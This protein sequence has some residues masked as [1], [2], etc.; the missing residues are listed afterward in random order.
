MKIL[1]TTFLLIF[2]SFFSFAQ[3]QEIDSLKNVISDFENSKNF[4]TNLNYLDAL[5]LL[6]YKYYAF[7]PD[8]M[9]ILAKKSRKLCEQANY[10]IGKIEAIR[11][12]GIYFDV[13]GDFPQALKYFQE[14]MPLAQKIDY[15][16]GIGRLYNNIALIYEMEGKYD[17]VLENHFKSLKIKEE[18]GDKEGIAASLNNIASIYNSQANY[19][20]ALTHYFKSLGICQEIGD[21]KGIATALNNIAIIYKIQGN[22]PEALEYYFKSLKIDEQ[23]ENK[24][25]IAATL[26]GI[27]IV[28]YDQDKYTE[29]LENQ[30]K[31]LKINEEIGNKQGIAAN[32][33]DIAN[34]YKEQ[35]EYKIALENLFK[36][37]KIK[38]EMGNKQGINISLNHI[39]DI[40]ELQEKHDLAL[41]YYSQSLTISLNLGDQSLISSNKNG[42]ARVYFSLKNYAKALSYAQEGL[43]L[44]RKIGEK[45][46]I[47]NISHTLS[48]IYAATD[49]YKEAFFYYQEFKT[50]SDSLYN[51]NTDEKI[52][53]LQAE[54]KYD[55]KLAA[56]QI[57]QTKKDLETEK[58]LQKNTFIRNGFIVGFLAMSIIVFIIFRNLQKQKKAKELLQDRN[59][60]ILQKN[61]EII[62]TNEELKQANDKIHE[63]F[64][65]VH[66]K[67]EEITASINY[68]LRIQN[69][70]LPTSTQIQQYFPESFVLYKPKDI[71]SGDFYWFTEKGN[72]KIIAVVDCTGHGVSGA[73]MTIIGNNILNQ[74]VND[75]EVYSPEKIL[76]LMPLLLKKHL[77]NSNGIVKDGMD[78]SIISISETPNGILKLEYAGAMNPLYYVQNQVFKEIKAD[79]MPIGEMNHKEN[80]EYQ[81]HEILLENPITFYLCSDGFQDQFGGVKNKKFMV[82]SLK[83]LLFEISEKPM[84]EQGEILENTLNHWISEGKETQV[85]DVVILGIRINL[86]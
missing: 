54:Y 70:I 17:L 44:A 85:D 3:K 57:E 6:S 19:A 38:E 2:L 42:L 67:N 60:E 14:A 5:N 51:Q 15:K 29:S 8:T 37:L 27:A 61:D 7:S 55:K 43:H 4:E 24:Q 46:T 77:S 52:I 63:A 84:E 80:F 79:K 65:I 16:K 34:V 48:K 11:N 26:I 45:E 66:E 58:E 72:H 76:N 23:I 68:A 47:K 59:N 69:A 86:K 9:L 10:E 12:I 75:Y 73:F 33:T 41:D 20:Q 21:K 82:S 1:I 83:K 22:Y 62:E 35:G 49:K 64:K 30:F 36:S 56:M 18:I 32:W 13:E 78:I 31:S 28:Y 74:I 53:K 39:A 40:Y 25:G 71:V 81:K 50:L